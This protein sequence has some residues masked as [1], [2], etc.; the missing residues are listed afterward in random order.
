[1]IHLLIQSPLLLLF[2]V[3]AIG[4]P[5][6]RLKLKGFSLGVAAVL[7]AGLAIG[8][9]DPRLELPELVYQLG[10]V[11][12][13]Y[14]MGLSSGP[15]FFASLRR[16]GL[17]DGLLVL[18]LLCFAGV[19]AGALGLVFHLKPSLTAGMYA[20]SLT[21]T[22]ALAAVLEHLKVVAPS[23][24]LDQALA[25]P[26]VAYS[27][28][29]P[30][31]VI[32]VILTF[33][34]L[35]RLWKVDY[36]R[37]ARRASSPGLKAEPLRSQTVR[38]E[39]PEAV[40]K[41]VSSLVHARSWPALFGR[42]K[43]GPGLKL[44]G[45]DTVFEVG[46]LVTVIG[47]EAGLATVLPRLGTAIEE[48]LDLDHHDLDMRRIFVSNP[49]VFGKMIGELHLSH[50]FAA[51]ITRVRRGDVDLLGTDDLVLEAGDRIR[52]VA[53]RERLG[54]ACRF[55]GDS[56]KALGEIDILTLSLGIAL[57]LLIGKVPF[58]VPWGGDF[59]LGSAGGT[60][61]AG[62]ILGKLGK[63]GPL[64][65]HLPYTAN[66]TLR[67]IGLI[68]FLAGVGTRAGYEFVTT[69]EGGGGLVI[70]LGGVCITIVSSTLTLLI[71]F[72]LL[73][74]PMGI[75]A[76]M[77]AGLHTQPAVLGFATERTQDDLPGI[78]Y[79]TVFPVAMI[80]KILVAQMLLVFC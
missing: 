41:H 19:L 6:G 68:L 70:F 73:H 56:M 76:G 67:Q 18:L 22:P 1:M 60:L 66:L 2:A 44:V 27:V 10:L 52:V 9:L 79:A 4:Y 26:V 64:Q 37:E 15:S 32:G 57:G 14:T 42:M 53:P 77:L 31:G 7:F 11:M 24:S 39:K 29:Y 8:S 62:L 47:T 5:L 13:V 17:R 78:G 61:I 59:E 80:A 3:A 43:R 63:T 34:I 36:S 20:G 49:Q 74:I 33:F 58:R 51:L 25:D 12:F 75:L 30:A 46:D 48:R 21:N 28:T 40:G 16:T 71:G 45:G 35:E 54:E 23:G 55:F 69:L 65:W 50:R 38:I 72:K